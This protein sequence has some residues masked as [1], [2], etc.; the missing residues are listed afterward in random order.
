MHTVKA[1]SLADF[2][3]LY[4]LLPSFFCRGTAQPRRA[5]SKSKEPHLNPNSV[6]ARRLASRKEAKELETRHHPPTSLE[7]SSQPSSRPPSRREHADTAGG[8]LGDNS[9]NNTGSSSEH[10]KEYADLCNKALRKPTGVAQ[11]PPTLG[12]GPQEKTLPPSS[13]QSMSNPRDAPTRSA[14]AVVTGGAESGTSGLSAGWSGFA[15]FDQFSGTPAAA[16]DLSD[17]F[18][19]VSFDVSMPPSAAAPADPFA[20]APNS[21]GFDVPGSTSERGLLLDTGTMVAGSVAA[22]HLGE[23]V[24]GSG[25]GRS[26]NDDTLLLDFRPSERGGV[27]ATDNTSVAALSDKLA[28]V[29]TTPPAPPGVGV[30]QPSFGP[31]SGGG[32]GAWG[33]AQGP[34]HPHAP[35]M[36]SSDMNAAPWAV[37]FN[38]GNG[39]GDTQ[40]QG[41][42]SMAGAGAAQ[43]LAA[44]Q[45]G[46]AGGSLSLNSGVAGSH[47]H[48]RSVSASNPWSAPASVPRHQNT[49]TTP[50]NPP[51]QDPRQSAGCLP[52]GQGLGTMHHPHRPAA[53]WHG[54]P[55]DLTVSSSPFDPEPRANGDWIAGGNPGAVT[56]PTVGSAG[57]VRQ[58]VVEQGS[59]Q[60]F[61]TRSASPQQNAAQISRRSHGH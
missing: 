26:S 49:V 59:S 50:I 42:A 24:G 29:F 17:G 4:A 46:F 2:R 55:A 13:Q 12:H 16:P 39:G 41:V 18:G 32:S 9:S 56:K 61:P 10:R 34:L 58:G 25:D 21:I 35:P 31:G 47:D 23:Q 36:A 28:G 54:I 53:S 48:Q 52:V 8:T 45:G 3:V 27:G 37:P 5:G 22:R 38:T 44:V 60:G 30:C 7:H 57:T 19:A 15:D 43:P 20:V 51:M 33:S 1:S 14:T 6:A 40:S 11:P